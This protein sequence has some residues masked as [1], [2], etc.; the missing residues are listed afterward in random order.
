[1][2]S[3]RPN[4]V[5]IFT[6][7]QRFDMIRSL[8]SS[9]DAETPHMD[10][11]VKEGITFEN[12]YC[13]APICS[14]SRATMMTG[15]YPSQTGMPGNLYAPCPPLTPTMPTV[16]NFFRSA[17]YETVYHGKWHMGG[18]VKSYGFEQGAETGHDATAVAMAGR[19]WSERDWAEH[20]RPFMH[21]VS[22][23]NPHDCYFHDPDD[24]IKGFKRPWKNLNVNPSS[25][26]ETV[27]SRMVDWPEEQWGGY[28]KWFSEQLEHADR[29]LGELLHQLRCSGFFNN[30]W[31][32]F[33]TD[34][35]DMAGEHNIP[36]K[37]PYMYEGVTRVP[38]IIIPPMT[39]FAGAERQNSFTHD[40]KPGKRHALCSLIDLLPTM[41]DI[42][43][44][45]QPANLPGKSLF[46]VVRGEADEVREEVFAEWHTPPIRMVR[47]ARYK[48]VLYLNRG[49]ELYD[50]DTDPHETKNLAG[51]KKHTEIKKG[52]QQRLERHIQDTNDPFHDM[53]KYEFLFN[54]SENHQSG[55]GP[56]QTK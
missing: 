18:D 6:D 19:F 42:A 41:M 29:D 13:T 52:L 12:C 40:I 37:G 10:F 25:V 22:L 51:S 44:I 31:I 20:E 47:D 35:G 15:L 3:K 14:P 43:G 24:H 23:L 28:H 16:G 48:Y 39:R 21:V 4:I 55:T 53:D 27:A 36:F 7:Q 45:E 38:L 54:P 33:T 49:E 8:G 30:S 2:S 46:P 9:F 32:I 11:L 56:S 26:P 1:M 34:H 5:L 50:L 17:G